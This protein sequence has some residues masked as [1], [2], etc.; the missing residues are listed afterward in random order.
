M[1]STFL[2]GLREGLEAALIVAILVAYVV[3]LDRRDLL[4]RLWIGVGAAIALSLGAAIV[5]KIAQQSLS[6]KAAE[7]FAGITSILAVGLITWM[8][9][10][11]A[12]SRWNMPA[13]STPWCSSRSAMVTTGGWTCP[14]P[15]RC[16]PK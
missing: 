4:P 6:D 15:K 2:I 7:T 5:L 3:K 10:W 9:F 1:L 11:M 8:I 12:T 14:Q 13:R 16:G